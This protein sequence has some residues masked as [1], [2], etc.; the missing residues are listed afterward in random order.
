M[1]SVHREH[2]VHS[3]ENV[4]TKMRLAVNL[5]H[6]KWRLLLSTCLVCAENTQL[7]NTPLSVNKLVFHTYH[8]ERTC[9]RHLQGITKG[10]IYL[11]CSLPPTILFMTLVLERSFGKEK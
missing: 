3:K 9:P 2:R 10:A 8:R 7:S 6:V 11:L 1:F 5:Q 4:T